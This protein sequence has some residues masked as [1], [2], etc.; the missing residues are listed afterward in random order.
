MF[1][2]EIENERILREAF[3]E[4]NPNTA[5]E[6]INKLRDSNVKLIIKR[7]KKDNIVHE[8]YYNPE[9]IDSESYKLYTETV[10][11]ISRKILDEIDKNWDKFSFYP[12]LKDYY[13]Y[14]HD[15]YSLNIRIPL[16]LTEA[17]KKYHS[18]DELKSMITDELLSK[19][20]K[21][22]DEYKDL[23]WDYV[24]SIDVDENGK[25]LYRLRI[26]YNFNDSV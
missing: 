14:R 9:D 12:L 7:Y 21:Y 10:D 13:E 26:I 16:N 20:N 22:L 15:I 1:M 5:I 6:I 18:I 23:I 17:Y 19:I 24:P 8:L 11:T 3:Y 25:Y 2:Y 4:Y